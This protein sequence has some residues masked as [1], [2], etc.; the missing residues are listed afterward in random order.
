ML[1]RPLG[2]SFVIRN[3]YVSKEYFYFLFKSTECFSHSVFRVKVIQNF[4]AKFFLSPGLPRCMHIRHII[5]PFLLVYKRRLVVHR[6][7]CHRLLFLCSKYLTKKGSMT[8]IRN[9]CMITGRTH[10]VLRNF[11]FSRATFKQMA[12]LG[13]LGGVK[14]GSW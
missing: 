7:L 10:S 6:Y 2:K 12:T 5:K 9:F 14:K 3:L 8:L 4:I 11:S 1:Y 13:L